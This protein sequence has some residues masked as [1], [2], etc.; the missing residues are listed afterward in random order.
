[1]GRS[2][3]A[4]P[5]PKSVVGAE[6]EESERCWSSE[7]CCSPRNPTTDASG[8]ENCRVRFFLSLDPRTTGA[9]SRHEATW[10]EP[11]HACGLGGSPGNHPII[12]WAMTPSAV[13]NAFAQRSERVAKRARSPGLWHMQ[14]MVTSCLARSS[15]AL[16]GSCADVSRPAACRGRGQAAR[17]AGRDPARPHHRRAPPPPVEPGRAYCCASSEAVLRAWLVREHAAVRATGRPPHRARTLDQQAGPQAGL[18]LTRVSLALD[19]LRTLR[20]RVTR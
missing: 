10:K 9:W 16:R 17:H 1:M 12:C 8:A 19:R 4:L 14:W 11:S 5:R 20:R 13:P 7:R 6:A 15:G 2:A 18:L 3:P